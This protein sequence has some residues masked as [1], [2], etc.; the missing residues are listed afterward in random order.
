MEIHKKNSIFIVDDDPDDRQQIL[1]AFLEHNAE[2]DYVF[3]EDGMQLIKLLSDAEP[4]DY[5]SVILLDLNMQGML[6]LHALKEI[7]D[8]KHYADIAI[9]VLT[10]STYSQ[11]KSSA[12][13]LGVNKIFQKPNS[14]KELQEITGT[15]IKLWFEP[16]TGCTFQKY[17]RP[18]L[19][20]QQTAK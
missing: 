11:D 12:Y 5:P 19:Q 3:I 15:I 14:Y 7:R 9:V 8:N 18:L 4:N 17:P 1:D 2:I 10:T 16:A 20:W 6:G 13:K